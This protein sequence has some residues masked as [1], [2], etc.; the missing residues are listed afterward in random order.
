MLA[1]AGVVLGV[2]L[3]LLPMLREV[4]DRAKHGPVRFRDIALDAAGPAAET[5]LKAVAAWCTLQAVR[6]AAEALVAAGLGGLAAAR[7]LEH[8]LNFR[9]PSPPCVFCPSCLTGQRK[10]PPSP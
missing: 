6:S 3:R 10:M 5:V 9:P 7:L 2:V 1:P 8:R 4:R